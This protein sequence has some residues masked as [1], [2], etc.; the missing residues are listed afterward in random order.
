MSIYYAQKQQIKSNTHV[1]VYKNS[2]Y[3]LEY[4]YYRRAV[5]KLTKSETKPMN[6]E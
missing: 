3:R 4:R 6:E 1:E 2:E 5:Q